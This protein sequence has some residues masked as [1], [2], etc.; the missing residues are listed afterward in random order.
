MLTAT[1]VLLLVTAV[2]C[3]AS[4]RGSLS[5]SIPAGFGMG[6][7]ATAVAASWQ[8]FPQLVCLLWTVAFAA[9]LAAALLRKDKPFQAFYITWGLLT[10]VIVAAVVVYHVAYIIG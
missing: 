5:W 3:I 10:A 4:W 9:S 7:S 6:A 2:G 1:V 8:H